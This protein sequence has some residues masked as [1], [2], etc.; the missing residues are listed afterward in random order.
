MSSR[1]IE[2]EICIVADLAAVWDEGA[3]RFAAAAQAAVAARGR[4]AVALSGGSTP[5][6]LYRELATRHRASGADQS[7]DAPRVPWQQTHIFFGDERY[8][9][10]DDSESNFRM[11]R[12]ALLD[13]VP[14]PAEQVHA[15][16]TD[17][18][19][20]DV[21]AQKYEATLATVFTQCS[22]PG[23]QYSEP[24]SPFPCFDLILLGMGPD[25][26][27][28]SL[29]PGT[30][31]VHEQHRWV[32]APWVDKFQTFRLTLTPPVINQ[33]RQVLF[34]VSGAS[35][36]QTLR[37]VL[38]GARDP[39]RLPSQIVRPAEG[40]LIWLIDRDAAHRLGNRK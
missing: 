7:S 20:P 10:H 34:L 23:N 9:P 5:E 6:G 4:F 37:D 2:P 21:A 13:H 25:G 22:V 1:S 39:S 35:K 36:A 8:V 30:D 24:G 31:A 28:A 26:H 15:M 29:F 11:A 27:T 18:A 12:E 3:R 17:A 16:P 19:D 33:G 38:E 40:Q 14:I 32:L